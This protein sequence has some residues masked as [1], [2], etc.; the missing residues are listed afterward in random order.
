MKDWSLL[1]SLEKTYLIW[2]KGEINN[3]IDEDNSLCFSISKE[4]AERIIRK[5]GCKAEEMPI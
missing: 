2:I 4:E 1:V 5:T 3:S